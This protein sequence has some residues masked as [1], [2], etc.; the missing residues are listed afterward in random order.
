MNSSIAGIPSGPTILQG[1]HRRYGRKRPR[2][3]Q[4]AA[5][6]L[7]RYAHWRHRPLA[8]HLRRRGRTRS[9]ATGRSASS[10]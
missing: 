1:E 6:A 10:R 9:M 7:I 4:G 8:S 5:G 2:R 3:A